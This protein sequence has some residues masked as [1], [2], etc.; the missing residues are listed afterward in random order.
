MEPTPDDR[1]ALGQAVY[2]PGVLAFYDVGVLG[3]SCSFAWR[4]PARRLLGVYDAHVTARHLECGVGTGWFLDRCRFPVERP[5]IVLCDLN[6]TCLAQTAHRIRRYA[7]E[8]I[9]ANLLEPLPTEERFDS[10]GCNFVLHC[11]PGTFAEK[12]V[13]FRHLRDRLAPGGVLIGSTLLQGDVPTNLPARALMALYNRK[14]IFSNT[15]DTLAGLREALAGAFD[16]VSLELWG[17]TGVFV[18]RA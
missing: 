17:N 7:P 9:R 2:T 4:A 16:D 10:I 5:R 15:G 3:I 14:G 1:V 12:G 18:A 8:S 11:I 6:P 13:V